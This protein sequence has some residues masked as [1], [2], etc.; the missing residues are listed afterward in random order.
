MTPPPAKTDR[1]IRAA[2]HLDW[3]VLL[4]LPLLGAVAVWFAFRGPGDRRPVPPR[5]PGVEPAPAAPEPPA[6]DAG[7]T[8][9]RAQA[10][11]RDDARD[12]DD[13]HGRAE[14]LVDQA[15]AAGGEDAGSREAR[16]RTAL[17]LDPNNIRALA[18]LGSS[19][20]RRD[21]NADAH[22]A[23]RRCLR[24]DPTN[25]ECATVLVRSSMRE[26]DWQ[27]ARDEID[28]CLG[29]DPRPP[30]CV[31]SLARLR[32]VSHDVNAARQTLALVGDAGAPGDRETL[33]ADIAR[34]EGRGE[35]ARARYRAACE[36]GETYACRQLTPA[37]DAGAR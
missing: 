34:E 33:L 32:V 8:A 24:V 28:S 22:D 1:H 20:S 2:R 18:A 10:V 16:L 29:I 31:I 37:A 14:G 23:A 19:L 21:A 4:A 11:P 30:E 27:S 35:E 15:L 3:L 17:D 12:T 36:M 5:A 9:P 26:G 6:R 13:P 25:P 7:S